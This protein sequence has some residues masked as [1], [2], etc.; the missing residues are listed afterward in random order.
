MV[1]FLLLA[2]GV[3]AFEARAGAVA[4][5][6]GCLLFSIACYGAAFAFFDRESEGRN[7]HVFSTWAA[8]LFLTG[9]LLCLSGLGLTGCLGVAAL[10]SSILGAH[11]DRH[12]LKFHGLVFL[13][14]AAVQSGMPGYVFNA[15]AGTLPGWAGGGVWL[16][17]ACALICY[18]ANKPESGESRKEQLLH[19]VPA[20]LAV[21]AVA[22]FLVQGLL[23]IAALRM[24]TD[25]YHVAF[26]RTLIVCVAALA[27][28][29]GGAR[30]R[31]RELTRIAY[32]TLAFAAVKLVFEDLRHGHMEFIAASIFL[33]AM[34]LIV[35][36]RLARVEKGLVGERKGSAGPI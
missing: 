19:L 36:P 31:R 7:Y 18:V 35:V 24:T 15:L 8:G 23:W 20:A 34:T 27:L 6:L 1:A 22:A 3:V 10:I 11:F 9:S 30:W 13:T 26:I 16:V 12:T 17:T 28:A 14:A 33:F 32:A 29:Y 2:W 25:V 21:S 4:L 5:G